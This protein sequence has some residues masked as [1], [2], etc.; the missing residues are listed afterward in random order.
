MLRETNRID[1]LKSYLHDLVSA[2]SDEKKLVKATKVL[3]KDKKD[4]WDELSSA[5]QKSLEVALKEIEDGK[6][7]ITHAAFKKTTSKLK[8]KWSSKL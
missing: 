7:I 3:K 6:D 8:K 2:T 1:E 4:W 5:E